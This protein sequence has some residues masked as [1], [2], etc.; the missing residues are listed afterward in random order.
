MSPLCQLGLVVDI[1]FSYDQMGMRIVE[2][3]VALS[4]P[5]IFVSMNYR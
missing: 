5:V 4:S 1:F 3:S 2:R